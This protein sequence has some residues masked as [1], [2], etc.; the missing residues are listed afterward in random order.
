MN[1][2][3]DGLPQHFTSANV[4]RIAAAIAQKKTTP[5][6]VQVPQSAAMV[7]FLFRGDVTGEE[8]ARRDTPLRTP[9][10]RRT[11]V[12][13]PVGRILRVPERLSGFPTLLRVTP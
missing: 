10:G 13:N 5:G 4:P 12:N 9:P 1:P 8:S 7:L 6:F 11:P 3:P 2:G